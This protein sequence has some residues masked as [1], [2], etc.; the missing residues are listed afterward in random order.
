MADRAARTLR[1]RLCALVLGL[2]GALAAGATEAPTPKFH[3]VAFCW[4]KDL[5]QNPAVQ[6]LLA[7]D[8]SSFPLGTAPKP[9]EIWHEGD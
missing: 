9:H 4:E 2:C 7:I 1:H 8:P 6:V 5:G 3:L